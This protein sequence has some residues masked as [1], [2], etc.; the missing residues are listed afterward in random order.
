MDILAKYQKKRF[1]VLAKWP[2]PF[3][4]SILREPFEDRLEVTGLPTQKGLPCRR[5]EA[6][7]PFD[8]ARMNSLYPKVLRIRQPSPPKEQ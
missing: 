5:K 3:H 4:R 1:L 7:P 8:H 6:P 2:Q